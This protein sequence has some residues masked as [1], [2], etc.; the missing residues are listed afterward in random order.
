MTGDTLFLLPFLS[1]LLVAASL[2]LLGAL[3]R[4]REEWLAALGF[5][6]LAGAGGLIGLALHL[7]VVLG[8]A[9]GAAAGALLKGLGRLHGNTVYALMML[10]GWSATLLMAANSAL[11]SV[12][13]HA[14]VEGQLYFAGD[15]HLVA[16]VALGGVTLAGLRWLMPALVRE[17]LL[18]GQDA[19]NRLPTRRRHLGFDLLTALGMAVGTATIGLMG[20]FALVFVPPWLAFRVARRW[21]QALAI[22]VGFGLAG[23]TAAFALALV[24]DQ[25]FG[26]VLVG[27]LLTTA[28]GLSVV[29]RRLS[30]A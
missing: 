2:S 8:A 27:L 18:P 12:M 7:P 30:G 1:G 11:G 24:L 14:M 13:G 6:H 23:Y 25:P 26:P 20:A 22:S 5:A 10:A 19:A 28:G 4:L 29:S 16:A 9:L 3:L 21:R 15:L 17:R